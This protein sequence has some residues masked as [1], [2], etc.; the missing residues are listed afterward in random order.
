MNKRD[1]LFRKILSEQHLMEKYG[2]NERKINELKCT[3]PHEMKILKVL[4]AIIIDND[5][6]RTPRQIYNGLKNIHNL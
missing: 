5:N 2:L 1:V 4:A 3:D 6:N